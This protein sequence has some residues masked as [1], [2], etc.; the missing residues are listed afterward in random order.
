M[1]RRK[2]IEQFW[3]NAFLNKRVLYMYRD[4]L[5]EL[6]TTMFEWKNLPD[7]VDERFIEQTLFDDGYAVWFRD[8][9]LGD[10]CLKCMIGGQWNVYNIPTKRKAY[11]TN[12]YHK[13]LTEKDSVLIY[14]NALRTPSYNDVEIFARKLTLMDRTI[15]TNISAQRTPVL[16]QAEDETQRLTMLNMYKEYD[17]NSPFIFVDKG[18][19]GELKTLST[20]A[21]Y[22]ADKVYELKI[23]EWNEFLTYMGITN[24]NVTKKERLISDEVTRSLGA[25]YAMR[26]SRLNARRKAVDEINKMFGLNIEVDFRQD[27]RIID[28]DYVVPDDTG[29]KKVNRIAIGKEEAQGGVELK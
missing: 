5:R 11:A 6:A 12:G 3:E 16:V 8:E 22:V 17:G 4:H 14:N 15:D 24:L 29:D 26:Y 25:I 18:L 2:K 21:P 27:Y 20:E 10:L 1:S 13:H 7:S 23:K 28:D 19:K 9:V